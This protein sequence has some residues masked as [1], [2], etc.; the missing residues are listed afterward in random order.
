M[1]MENQP[2]AE[3]IPKLYMPGDFLTMPKSSGKYFF[4]TVVGGKPIVGRV[5]E[6][7]TPSGESLSITIRF[8]QKPSTAHSPSHILAT[9][10]S[11]QGPLITISPDAFDSQL[12]ELAE[13]RDVRMSIVTAKAS[14]QEVRTD[15]ESPKLGRAE[16]RQE[17]QKKLEEAID[18][19]SAPSSVRPQQET[20]T[21]FERIGDLLREALTPDMPLATHKHLPFPAKL[22]GDMRPDFNTSFLKKR[23]IP[24]GTSVS[25]PL[26]TFPQ[27]SGLVSSYTFHGSRYSHEAIRLIK[28][29]VETLETDLTEALAVDAI[30]SLLE[31][32]DI[33]FLE[34]HILFP[35][36]ARNIASLGKKIIFN[37]KPDGTW[38][39]VA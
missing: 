16:S 21:R 24:P 10:Y 14:R 2:R 9:A 28:E 15:L 12:K 25:T 20:I 8:T 34:I 29:G 3:K 39:P 22:P 18:R 31:K 1:S 11:E 36:S 7:R 26:D 35:K 23:I 17:A 13:G 30:Q 37:K 5:W 33:R 32:K 19:F 38:G 27:V 6:L 4:R